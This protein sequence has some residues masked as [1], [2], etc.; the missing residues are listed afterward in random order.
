MILINYT[1][2]RV[3]Q[4]ALILCCAFFAQASF[5]QSRLN[6]KV[7]SS[8]DDAEEKPTGSGGDLTSSDLEFVTDGT[9][10][11]TVGMRFANIKLP[12]GALV[13]NAYIQFAV[14]ESTNIAPCNLIIKA[15]AT[16]NPSTFTTVAGTVS[17]RPTIAQSVN[18]TPTALWTTVGLAGSDQKT[19]DLKTLVQALVD[20]PNWVSGNAMSFIVT[21]TGARVAQSYDRDPAKAPELVV[22]YY[23]PVTAKFLI[24]GSSDDAEEK[25]SG[26]VGDLTSSDLELVMDGSSSQ[27]IGLRFSDINL[28]KGAI[29]NKA[30][31]QFA[32]DEVTNVN[33]CNLVIK[34]EATDNSSTF[35]SAVGTISTRSTTTEF[36]NWSPTV[37]WTI[38]GLAGNDQK[39]PELKTLVEAIINRTGWNSGNAMSFIVTGTGARVAQSFDRDPSKAAVLEVEYMGLDNLVKPIAEVGTFPIER[40]SQWKYSDKGVNLDGIPWNAKIYAD[41]ENWNFGNGKLGY[42]QVALGT[43]LGYGIDANNKYPTTYLRRTIKADNVSQFESLIVY[44]L[45]DDG[46]VMYINGQEVLR[47]NVASP[48]TFNTLASSDVTGADESKYVRNVIN[49]VL[50]NNEINTIAIEIHQS[51]LSSADLVF[52]MQMIGKLAYPT[53]TN[54]PIKKA[55]NWLYSDIGMDLGTD[56]TQ[57]TYDDSAWDNGLGPLG[58]TDPV[59]SIISF[60]DNNDNKYTTSYFRK[61]FMVD[62]LSKITSDLQ[63]NAMIDDGAVI[64]INGV[65]AIRNNMPAGSITYISFASTSANEGVY[66]SF[67]IPKNVLIQGENIIAVEVHQVEANSSDLVFDLELTLKSDPPTLAK[68]C[69]GPNDTHI[70]CFNSVAPSTKSQLLVIPE[71]HSFQLLAQSGAPYTVGIGNIGTNFDFTGFIPENNTSSTKGKISLNHETNP[72]GVSMFDVSFDSNSKLWSTDSSRGIDFSGV[73]GTRSNCSGGIT[74]WG[75]VVTAEESRGTTDSNSDGYVDMGW[76]VE[77]DPK[78]NKIAEY[79][80]GKAQ[81]LWAMGNGSHE[82][83]VVASDEIT[84]YWGEDATDGSVFKYVADNK[85]DL[86]AGKL[87]TLNLGSQLLSNEPQSATGVWTLVPNTTATQRNTSYAIAKSLGSTLFRGVE[88]VEI[89]TL[90]N[91]IYFA[92]KGNNRVYRFKD[93]GTTISEFE[94]FI[95]G[96]SY[97]FL[98]DTNQEITEAWGTGNDNLAF[99]DRGN[100]YVLQDGDQDHIW[101]VRP[102]HKQDN[103]KIE[104]FATTPI[105]SEPTG[106]TFSPDYKYMFI[107]MQEPA[108][109]NTATTVDASGKTFAFNKSTMLVIARKENLGGSTLSVEEINVDS[110]NSIIYPNPTEGRF[111]VTFKLAS[112]GMVKIEIFDFSGKFITTLINKEYT[113]GQHTANFQ[114]EKSGPYLVK[115]LTSAGTNTYKVIVK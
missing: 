79:G 11:Q 108:T 35:T 104:L 76:L 57:K 100:L 4:F 97:S 80:T 73:V 82:N 66:E 115:I 67:F 56:W 114:L 51:T 95:G 10:N 15:E 84:A 65:E 86:S 94:T 8:S 87:Y 53:T 88:D 55:S 6:V 62:D 96:S 112:T 68:G 16:D 50:L 20:R 58:Y 21:G 75:T 64:Y 1:K 74:P 32:V 109:S 49:N 13:S 46:F 31:I 110:N 113:S 77:I 61:K 81:K 89:G 91:K 99:D 34:G 54:F 33:P 19:P 92:S 107:S 14:D 105:G 24:K 71:T 25:P 43:T 23:V 41:D 93:N 101:M 45:A 12:K 59:T 52:D 106:I 17:T 90:D 28:P 85:G 70:A 63:I 69:T 40:N 98:T 44:T 29:I 48:S 7:T 22:E 2:L 39:T 102:D 36:V 38:D 5:A 27:T 26:A 42:G 37:S 78:T 83:V 72:G 18:W 3:I 103:P 111:N 9:S 30:N 60:G 47:R